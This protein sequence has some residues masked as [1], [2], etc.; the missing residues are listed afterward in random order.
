MF[1]GEEEAAGVD[2]NGGCLRAE[3]VNAAVDVCVYLCVCVT[4]ELDWAV[5]LIIRQGSFFSL[6]P[7]AFGI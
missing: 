2:F 6:L 7:A 4:L 3:L 5:E 1:E